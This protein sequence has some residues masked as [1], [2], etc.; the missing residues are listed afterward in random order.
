MTYKEG[1]AEIAISQQ[2]PNPIVSVIVLEFTSLPEVVNCPQ[3]IDLKFIVAVRTGDK[4]FNILVYCPNIM[5]ETN[6]LN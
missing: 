3:G 2:A 6:L 5:E 1:S 4:H